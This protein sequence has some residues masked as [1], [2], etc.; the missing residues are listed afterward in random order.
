M[1]RATDYT[2]KNGLS[3][4]SLC[5]SVAAARKEFPNFCGPNFS[6]DRDHNHALLSGRGDHLFACGFRVQ[7]FEAGRFACDLRLVKEVAIVVTFEHEF[8][9]VG[10][11]AVYNVRQNHRTRWT[12]NASNLKHCSIRARVDSAIAYL[13]AGRFVLPAVNANGML[14]ITRCGLVVCAS[15]ALAQRVARAT[16]S[17]SLCR[18]LFMMGLR[19]LQWHL[20]PSL[21]NADVLPRSPHHPEAFVVNCGDSRDLCSQLKASRSF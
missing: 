2:D 11:T 4:F 15:A 7:R 14:A 17:I 12:I 6:S 19:L 16:L 21:I 20:L 9:V 8:R 18:C 1:T 3:V 10:W 5:K 13:P